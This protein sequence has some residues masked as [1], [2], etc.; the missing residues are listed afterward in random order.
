MTKNGT[1]EQ[2]AQLLAGLDTI[3]RN[4]DRP[5]SVQ[6]LNASLANL[7]QIETMLPKAEVS[8]DERN[9]LRDRLM[10][11][12][13]KNTKKLN[14]ALPW[15]MVV[16]TKV[17]HCKDKPALADLLDHSIYWVRQSAGFAL[18]FAM[19][20]LSKDSE[21]IKN[22]YTSL[23]R[24]STHA[25]P[26]VRWHAIDLWLRVPVEIATQSGLS[27][28]AQQWV[29]EALADSEP[30]V[31]SSAIRGLLL[32]KPDGYESQLKAL[33][34]G[35]PHEAIREQ[36][37][38]SHTQD[39]TE[40]KL[41]ACTVCRRIPPKR[42]A[43]LFSNYSV[44]AS[45]DY[46]MAGGA[47]NPFLDASCIPVPP[48]NPFDPNE[49]NTVRQQ[50]RAEGIAM[51]RENRKGKPAWDPAWVVC[52]HCA[53]ALGVQP[54]DLAKAHEEAAK[55][56]RREPAVGVLT[57]SGTK[58]KQQVESNCFVCSIVLDVS[59]PELDVF[60]DFRDHRLGITVAGRVFTKAYYAAG[61][62]LATYVARRP[63]LRRTVHRALL[64]LLPYAQ[65]ATEAQK[66]PPPKSPKTEASRRRS[67]ITHAV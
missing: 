64:Q 39:N 7:T 27:S 34:T 31:R 57:A 48:R 21:A 45:D 22:L 52:G 37:N 35:D 55:H 42:F 20:G 53:K 60:R 67:E 15:P 29:R 33:E 8:E 11:V 4:M 38:H 61:P 10:A 50:Q 56:F 28:S 23:Q 49:W 16:M 54:D 59:A 14:A 36:A 44:H 25:D 17:N 46:T 9:L 63:S 66:M 3:E 13:T 40:T 47:S 58:L 51:S 41:E 19:D 62:F 6:E 26:D 65:R 2:V 1:K 5:A 18:Q 12:K 43:Y 30:E 24:L 32:Y